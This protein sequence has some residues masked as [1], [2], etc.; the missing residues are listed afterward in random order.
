V[1]S[2]LEVRVRIAVI[3]TS[4]PQDEDDPSGHFVRAEVRE[5]EEAGHEVVVI[6]PQPG[7]AFGWPG[8][9]A[10]LRERPVRALEAGAWVVR[11]RRSV[12]AARADRIVAHWAVP[13]AWPIAGVSWFGGARKRGR[14]AK[15]PRTPEDWLVSSLQSFGVLASWRLSSPRSLEVVSHGG[16]VRLLVAMPRLLRERVVA[17]IA[18]RA[19][20]WRFVSRALEE[21]L[22]RALGPPSRAQVE[23]IAEVR[24][25][26]LALPDVA[27]AVIAKRR[28]LGGL[29]Y[30]VT[31]GRLVASKRVD[32]V[33]A[34]IAE[35]R[36]LEALVVVG[37]GPERARL[38]DLA[39]RAG[40]DARFVGLVPRTEAL[41]WMGAAEVVLHASQQEGLSTV[42]REAE[43]LGVR[44]V[45]LT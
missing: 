45:V 40:V 23:R 13:C 22:L 26:R 34:H 11:A 6:A 38:E 29:R 5:Y 39:R 25:A 17:S 21:E 8:V 10:R 2:G 15:T 44:C 7:G 4:Y 20:V 32:R 24:G 27:E 35:T 16:D 18:S 30:A 33:I 28:E 3:T 9:A 31:V 42:V 43:A 1:P 14:T 12:Q 36:A 19:V 37:D 41:A